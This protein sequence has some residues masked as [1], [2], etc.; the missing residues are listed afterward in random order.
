[1]SRVRA[2]APTT[3]T[4]TPTAT[5]RSPCPTVSVSTSR[6]EAPSAMRIP[7]SCVRCENGVREDPVDARRAEHERQP[8]KDPEHP[9]KQLERPEPLAAHLVHRRDREDRK[10]GVGVTDGRA[11]GARQRRRVA[12][13]VDDDA[14]V[15]GFLQPVR[16]EDRRRRLGR[17]VHLGGQEVGHDANDGEPRRPFEV[18][19]PDAPADGIQ[20]AEVG[21]AQ[22]PFPQCVRPRG[23]AGRHHA[24]DEAHVDERHG[25]ALLLVARGEPASAKQRH[26]QRLEEAS[27]HAG[28]KH[29]P[30]LPGLDRRAV[31]DHRAAIAPAVERDEV[32]R[33]RGPD[34]GHALHARQDVLEAPGLGARLRIRVAG[35][36]DPHSRERRGL[37]AVVSH[38]RCVGLPP[39]L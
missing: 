19:Q 21:R 20:A 32:R 39:E 35:E 25:R 8:A 26:V 5:S 3:P 16:D 36:V 27:R 9:R 15:G 22:Q 7:N 14:G 18:E 4:T 11:Q 23:V 13:R 2:A 17:L 28:M 34:A 12:C 37:N 24:A 30:L 38:A 33:R 1:M 31:D 29:P 6:V 10:A